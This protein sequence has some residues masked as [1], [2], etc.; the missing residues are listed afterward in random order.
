MT[1]VEL[2][3]RAKYYTDSRMTVYVFEHGTVV[4][5]VRPGL[6]DEGAKRVIKRY[7][8]P[9]DGEGSELG[10]FEY[11]HMDDGNYVISFLGLY[12]FTIKTP[13][14][15]G[16]IPM[17]DAIPGSRSEVFHTDTAPAQSF[18]GFAYQVQHGVVARHY[19]GKDARGLKVDQRFEP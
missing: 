7:D 1:N 3:E 11:L 4:A 6:G 5:S 19:R 14:E 18:G 12:V 16:Q 10:D 9:R 17:A 2:L 13:E 15:L 8:V